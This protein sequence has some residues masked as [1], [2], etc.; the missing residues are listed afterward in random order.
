MR[1]FLAAIAAAGLATLTVA[2]AGAAA[3]A[4]T[5]VSSEPS[6]GEELHQAPDR[7]EVT[8]SE[9]LDQSS[10]LSVEDS[11]GRQVD[12]GEV[13]IDG[14]AMSVGIALEPSGHYQVSYTATG[15]AGVTGSTEGGFHFMVHFGDKCGGGKG[16]KGGHNNHGGNNTGGNG[17]NTGGNNTGGNGNNNEHNNHSGGGS[18]GGQHSSGSGHS[19]SGPSSTGTTDHAGSQTHGGG[20]SSMDSTDNRHGGMHGDDDNKRTK[21]H[22]KH[23]GHRKPKT[24]VA[25]PDQP[26]P[27]A[28]G[29]GQP[30]APDGSA[31]M[32]ALGFSLALG[33]LGGWFL[34]VSAVR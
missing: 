24:T 21:K 8:F 27:L 2:P 17:N 30:V 22:G 28:G 25:T 3:V 31:V 13:A 18:Q 9:P 7:V 26:G 10:K 14:S 4:P 32:L 23:R 5:Y 34:R 6:D 1:R 33:T 15:L 29:S 19:G 20:H 16:G 12:D 11:C